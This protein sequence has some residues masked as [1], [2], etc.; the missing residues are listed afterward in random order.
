MTATS[1]DDYLAGFDGEV[2]ER[3]DRVRAAIHS[4]LPDAEESIRYGMPAVALGARGHVY[5]A[6]WKKHIGF[7][8]VPRS[9]HPIEAEVAPYR[10]AKDT[11][12]FP[13]AQAQPDELIA[14]VTA[15]LAA[16]RAGA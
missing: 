1:V 15:H 8:P 12:R 9:A 16:G 2:R 13:Y 7:Y 14:R 3:L 5:F 11:L 6:A 10:D 4:V